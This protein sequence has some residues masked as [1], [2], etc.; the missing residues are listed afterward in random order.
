MCK[1]LRTPAYSQPPTISSEARNISIA[2]RDEEYFRLK[3]LA[4]TLSD[5]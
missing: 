5:V 2:L 3:I 4:C 1:H